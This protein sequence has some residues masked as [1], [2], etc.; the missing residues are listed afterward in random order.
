MERIERFYKIERLLRQ[1]RRVSRRE[2]LDELE[3]SLA[4]FKRDLEYMRDRLQAPIV[5]SAE[6]RAY[7]LDPRAGKGIE[8]PGLWFNPSEIHALL[9]M[10]AM[11]ASLQPG[12]LSQHV[13][14]LRARLEVLLEEGRVEAAEVRRRVRMTPQSARRLAPPVFEA[15]AAA[16][17]KRRRLRIRYAGRGSGETTE[18]EVSPQRL[19]HYRDNWYLD[20][21]CHLRGG[22]RKFAVDAIEAADVCDERA[23]NVDLREVEREFDSGYGVFG[24]A[25]VRWA[26]LRFTPER[27]RWVAHEQWHPAQRSRRED[28]GSF[29]L[30]VPFADHRELLMDVL[31]YGADVEVLGPPELAGVVADEVRRMAA[32][33]ANARAPDSAPPG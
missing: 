6:A 8:L 10:D 14:P 13:A 31:K 1:R 28:D 24:G 2:F 3:V 5:W 12:L 19:V 16:T 22:L 26:I 21:W 11:L 27:A 4:T 32:R 29:V 9:A 7:E 18:R 20:A 33:V 25:S 15:V 17:L 30:E 23:K